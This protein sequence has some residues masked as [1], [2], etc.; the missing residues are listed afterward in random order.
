MKR[1]SILVVLLCVI[2]LGICQDDI[3]LAEGQGIV[4]F[5]NYDYLE[6]KNSVIYEIG[7]QVN[8]GM[9]EFNLNLLK[10]R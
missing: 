3:V 5:N 4:Y 8:P 9:Y 6:N 7:N 1:N 2:V 10:L